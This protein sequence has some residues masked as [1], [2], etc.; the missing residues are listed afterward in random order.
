MTSILA[1]K[2]NDGN[3]M[4]VVGDTQHTY[5]CST[6]QGSKIFPL[7]N[8]LF[9]GSGSD[10]VIEDMYGKSITFK[11]QNNN[12]AK[13]I[14]KAQQELIKEYEEIK[15]KYDPNLNI[16][17]SDII[18]S[19]FMIINTKTLNGN[20]VNEK[21]NRKMKKIDMI[22]SG[23]EHIGNLKLSD[24]DDFEFNETTKNKIFD[25]IIEIYSYLGKNDPYTGH[26]SI[27]DLEVYVLTKNNNPKKY[28]LSFKHKDSK[29][30]KY[31][32]VEN[33]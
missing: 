33:D 32:V 8:L 14:I 6:L 22:G 12:C 15:R 10:R 27:F 21:I 28:V 24:A 26:P 16:D 2:I 9:C 31:D 18:N 29:I 13:N 4:I 1:F 20:I 5:Q 11:S 7:K 25:K 17:F 23:E 30:K 19:S 3:Q